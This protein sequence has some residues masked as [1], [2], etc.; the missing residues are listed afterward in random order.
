MTGLFTIPRRAVLVALCVSVVAVL[1][2]PATPAWAADVCATSGKPVADGTYTETSG[3][4]PRGNSIHRGIDLA[5]TVG[6]NIFASMDGTVSAA[7]PASGFGQW[8]VI[9][10]QTRTGLVSTVYGHMFPDGVLVRQGQSVREGEHIANIGNNGEST[11]PHLHFEYWEG[12]RLTHGHAIDPS[13]I[14]NSP[15]PP[16]NPSTGQ[17][18]SAAANCQTGVVLKPGLVPPVFV[19]WI[20]KAGAICEGI[21]A[22]ILAAQLEAE[23]GFRYG[24]SAPVSS[25]GAQGPAQFMPATWQTWGKDYDNSGPPPDV[26][27]IPDAVMSQGALMCENYRECAAGIANGSIAGDPVAL[28]LAS[29]NAGFGAVQ[30]AGGMPS[31]GDYTTQT[32]PYVAKI[33]QRSK[34]FEATPGLGGM[35]AQT[36]AISGGP[37]T[38]V[39]AASQFKGKK[40]VW[41]GGSVDG[42]TN[43]GFDSSGLTYYAVAHGSGGKQ[44]LPRTADEQWS[45]GNEIPLA[46]AQPG[47]LIFSGWDQHGRPSHV[48]IAVGNGQMIHADPARGVVVADYYPESKARRLS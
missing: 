11:G 23:N 3:F 47:D 41:G 38:T 19:P 37:T 16:T 21:K 29:Y 33:M 9:D 20:V 25:T 17:Q 44:V 2:T 30:R 24:A 31:G 15:P 48:G 5:G 36:V 22:P 18:A 42:P 6:T 14:L 26:N 1:V 12:G 28:A 27:S 4:G 43:D 8:I 10:S 39:D 34:A 32:Q 40:W 35:P 46:Q 13:F 7:G 45:V